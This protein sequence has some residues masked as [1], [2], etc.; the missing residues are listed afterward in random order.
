M[1][2][3]NLYLLK[4]NFSQNLLNRKT[5][6]KKGSP[7]KIQAIKKSFIFFKLIKKSVQ[8]YFIRFFQENIKD[9]KNMWK[10]IKKITSSNNSNYPYFSHCYY[11]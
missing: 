10:G 6:A 8:W 1:I 2:Y 3:K 9:L 5:L 11:S 7:H 4:S